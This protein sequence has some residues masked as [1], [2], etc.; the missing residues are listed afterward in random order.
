MARKRTKEK[1][2]IEFLLAQGAQPV[3]KKEKREEWYK[4]AKEEIDCF[5]GPRLISQCRAVSWRKGWS[6]ATGIIKLG[7]GGRRRPLRR[8]IRRLG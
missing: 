6:R 4:K 2:I 1:E 5:K 7:G 8:R 3:T